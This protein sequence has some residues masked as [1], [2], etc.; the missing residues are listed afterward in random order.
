MGRMKEV[1]MEIQHQK[2]LENLRK[3]PKMVHECYETPRKLKQS[4]NKKRK[5]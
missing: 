3:Y 2:E 1:F 4:F 5:K